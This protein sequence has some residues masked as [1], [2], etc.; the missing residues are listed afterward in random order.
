MKWLLVIIRV[1]VSALVYYTIGT[2]IGAGVE[3]GE[4]IGGVGHPEMGLYV[5]RH[6]MDI[7]KI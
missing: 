5:A 7:E 1:V 3:R 6:P 4:F 2:G